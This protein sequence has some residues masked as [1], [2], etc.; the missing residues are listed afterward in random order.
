MSVYL[1]AYGTF[2]DVCVWSP[3]R[4]RWW[5][6]ACTPSKCSLRSRESK[7]QPTKFSADFSVEPLEIDKNS[8]TIV[9]GFVCEACYRGFSNRSLRKGIISSLLT[10]AACGGWDVQHVCSYLLT[11]HYVLFLQQNPVKGTATS[12]RKYLSPAHKQKANRAR[13]IP[14]IWKI[15]QKFESTLLRAWKKR[16]QK[17]EQK[18]ST[19]ESPNHQPP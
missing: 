7:P 13:K 6:R 1:Y 3:L 8:A 12:N 18:W 16:V 19:I 9:A 4:D 10:M 17:W 15:G 2:S 11:S 14:L 5:W